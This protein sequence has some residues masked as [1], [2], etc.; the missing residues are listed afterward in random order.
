MPT[1]L[2]RGS[3]PQHSLTPTP[4]VAVPE[5]WREALKDR[6][7][8]LA[9]KASRELNFHRWP[10]LDELAIRLNGYARKLYGAAAPNYAEVR[11]ICELALARII[12]RGR[13]LSFEEFEAWKIRESRRRGI[14]SGV[15]R[16][17]RVVTRNDAILQARAQGEPVTEVASRFDLSTR[18]VKRVASPSAVAQWL[19]SQEG[20]RTILSLNPDDLKNSDSFNESS[21]NIEEDGS[22]PLTDTDWILDYWRDSVGN[23]LAGWQLHQLRSWCS[24]AAGDGGGVDLTDL[25]RCIDYAGRPEIRDPFRYVRV[26]VDRRRGRGPEYRQELEAA[27]GEAGRRYADYA[28][29]QNRRAYLA[30]C[31]RNADPPVTAET[32]RTGFLDSYRQRHGRLPWERDGNESSGVRAE[33]VEV[34][35]WRRHQKPEEVM[36]QARATRICLPREKA[37][38]V[39]EQ[40]PCGHPLAALLTSRM[41]LADVVQVQCSSGCGHWLYSD[42][43]PLECPCHLP[44]AQAARVAAA[45]QVVA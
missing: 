42:R 22:C 8:Q 38:P 21:E 15:V 18:Q 44:P 11:E 40:G 23:G 41:S 24:D 2:H 12:R 16:R 32:R 34:D 10:S 25:V 13:Q 28:H 27:A 31:A 20:T 36:E 1:A 43:G 9:Y 6:A 29:V 14:R 19:Q 39:S 33:P 5:L 26:A 7:Y 37:P 3:S 17:Q 35:E 30:T 45:L 4:A